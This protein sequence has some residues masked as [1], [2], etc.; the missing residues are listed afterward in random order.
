MGKKRKILFVNKSLTKKRRISGLYDQVLE[1]YGHDNGE[2]I[3][4]IVIFL[5]E[6]N[7]CNKQTYK[8]MDM[9]RFIFKYRK[10]LQKTVQWLTNM[11]NN[12]NSYAQLIL[13]QYDDQS[14]MLDNTLGISNMLVKSAEQGNSFA[15]NILGCE[16]SHKK[17][18]IKAEKWFIK[19]A[20][21]NN[22]DAQENLAWIYQNTCVNCKKNGF[23]LLKASAEQENVDAIYM[24]AMIYYDGKYKSTRWQNR[25]NKVY[26]SYDI[27]V[28][29]LKKGVELYDILCAYKLGSMY[30]LG[31]GV[32]K[33]YRKAIELFKIGIDIE[34]NWECIFASNKIKGYK[35]TQCRS[36]FNKM[37]KN[38][39]YPYTY[40]QTVSEWYKMDKSYTIYKKSL[41]KI[42]EIFIKDIYIPTDI[43]KMITVYASDYE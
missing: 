30:M 28:K 6:Y 11:A 3:K 1:L 38:L 5:E 27:A 20:D 19:S 2:C 13:V 10:V 42:K 34:G 31:I 22:R 26:Q 9:I 18:Y 29:W 12:K 7:I 15:Q 16:Y 24:L 36:S 33:N 40:P 37:N 39:G 25:I 4:M 23:E 21:Q 14:I 17:E 43:L 32:R 41:K 35:S 8:C